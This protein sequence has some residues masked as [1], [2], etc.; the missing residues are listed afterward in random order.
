MT[1]YNGES[2]PSDNGGRGGGEGGLVSKTF[3]GPSDNGGEGPGA[4]LKNFFGLSGLSLVKNNGG[5]GPPLGPS[6]GSTTGTV[7]Q[8]M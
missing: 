7:Q 5:A 2:G 1:E 8:L 6:P 4:G 3:F